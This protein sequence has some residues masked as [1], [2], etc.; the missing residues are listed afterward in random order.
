MDPLML[1]DKSTE[2]TAT[3]LSKKN[4][5][6]ICGTNGNS[7]PANCFDLAKLLCMAIVSEQL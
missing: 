4:N 2:E 5:H 3:T 1:I 7:V 6:E